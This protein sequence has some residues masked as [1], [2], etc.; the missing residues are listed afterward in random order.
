[1][2]RIIFMKFKEDF[3]IDYSLSNRVA[4]VTGAANGI[5]QAIALYFAK[6][7]AT[8]VCVDISNSVKEVEQSIKDLGGK[9]ISIVADLTDNAAIANVISVCESTFEKIDILVNCAGVVYLDDAENLSEEAWDK[10]MAVNL[11]APF[12]MAQAVGKTMI[13]NGGGKIV[14]LASSGAVVAFDKHVAYCASKGGIVLMTKVMAIEWAEYNINVNAISPTIVMTALGKKAWAG[15][16]GENMK[17]EIPTGRF[18]MPEE[19]AAMAAYLASDAADMVTG[20]NMVIDGGF[21]I[22]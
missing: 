10:T 19:V 14:N 20:T 18:C 3:S 6:K 2:R 4:V 1:M 17:K 9:A 16:K 13:K 21:T 7:G 11:K 12:M 8:I 22:K 15:E 5:G